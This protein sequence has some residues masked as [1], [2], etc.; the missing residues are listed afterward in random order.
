MPRISGIH[1]NDQATGRFP[2]NEFVEVALSQEEYAAYKSGTTKVRLALYQSDGRTS[3]DFRVPLDS[4]ALDKNSNEWVAVESGTS[5]FNRKGSDTPSNRWTVSSTAADKDIPR[6][7]SF[8]VVETVGV[9]TVDTSTDSVIGSDLISPVSGGTTARAAPTSG[10]LAGQTVN[11]VTINTTS[12]SGS[13]QFNVPKETKQVLA[14]T[15]PGDS[16]VIC[17]ATGTLILTSEGEIPIEKLKM[18]DS[19]MTMDMGHQ[20]LR[21][22]GNQTLNSETLEQKP[23]LRPI[24]IRA[25][26]LGGGLPR[27]DL[28]VSPQHRILASGPIPYRMFSSYE[29]LV[30]AK[31]LLELDGIEIAHD[32]SEVVYFHILLSQHQI[33]WANSAPAESLYPGKE[34]LGTLHKKQL[35]EIAEVFPELDTNPVIGTKNTMPLAPAR[36]FIIG[37]RSKN[38][39]TRIKSNSHDV[40]IKTDS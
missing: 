15:T 25:G 12:N 36:P 28:I 39:I 20:R 14:A 7:D 2:A 21:W 22:I 3:F 11:V 32:L 24:R 29:V 6:F 33:V 19:I 38:L 40:F 8:T 18:G 13:L 31:H 5:Y 1:F 30:A 10:R 27:S 4:F 17:F 26:A 37:R 9:Y 23:H 16:G 35:E 34:A